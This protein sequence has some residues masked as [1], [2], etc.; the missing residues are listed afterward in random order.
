MNMILAG[1]YKGV[2]GV[3][4]R[5]GLYIEENKLFGRR[6]RWYINKETVESYSVI[7]EDAHKSMSSGLIR[8]AVGAAV[9]GPVGAIAGAASAK[10]KSQYKV[11]IEFKDGTR[12]LIQLERIVYENL[13]NELY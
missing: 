6:K 13:V 4:F 11:S 12:A 3:S 5:K 2:I 7:D 9:L 1:D 8:G 10:K